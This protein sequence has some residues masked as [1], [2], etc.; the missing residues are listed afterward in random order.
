MNVHLCINA[1]TNTLHTQADSTMTVISVPSQ[2]DPHYGRLNP[3]FCFKVT[4]SETII[5][6]MKQHLKFS[7]LGYMLNHHQVINNKQKEHIFINIL[8][9]GNKRLFHNILKSIKRNMEIVET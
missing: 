3:H 8:S 6:R 5:I 4:K 1:E 9:Y 7:F 2:P